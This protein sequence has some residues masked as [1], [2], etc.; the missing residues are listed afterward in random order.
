MPWK[1]N[2]D[3]YGFKQES[4]NLYAP[5][6]SGV[7]GL[8]NFRHQ[9]LIGAAANI[10]NAVLHHRKHTKFRFRRFEP[11]GFTFEVCPPE[12]REFRARD[13]I[14]EYQPICGPQIPI[15]FATLCA[16][17]R[18]PQA[19]AFQLGVNSAKQPATEK[20]VPIA[21][22]LAKPQP[23]TQRYRGREQFSLAGA[24]CGV[25]F[26]AV[27]MIG[28]MPYLK[29]MF[30]S[31]VRNPAA[32]A[33]SR[34][35]LS[36][37]EIQLA[38]TPKIVADAGSENIA[39]PTAPEIVQPR[40]AGN[41]APDAIKST[42]PAQPSAAPQINP[43][44]TVGSLPG[45]SEKSVTRERPANTWSVQAMA[46]TEK[47]LASDWLQKLK[48]KGY[49]AFV[50]DADINGKTWHRVRIGSFATRRDAEDLRAALKEN[51]GFRDAFVASND[52]AET[53][54][55]LSRR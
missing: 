42:L 9:I 12:L 16:S 55:A 8:F 34:R 49:Q 30:A 14:A 11:T 5:T 4:I 36:D 41:S 48:V 22:K 38:Q 37:G 51:E 7:Y 6:A 23:Q 47:Q 26:L 3:Y 15:S 1:T 19:R 27:G 28:L 13:L 20:V 17:L 40:A 10:R 21:E 31:I 18:A 39:D 43:T 50:I 33:E 44:T 2:G 45:E 53:A 35:Q 29:N 46:T 32:I 54:I 52:K 25:V 24:V